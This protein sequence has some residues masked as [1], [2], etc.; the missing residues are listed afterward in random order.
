MAW[1]R[2]IGT[3]VRAE[4][5]RQNWCVPRPADLVAQ[6][7]YETSPPFL[8]IELYCHTADLQIIIA[9]NHDDNV[10]DRTLF[11]ANCGKLCRPDEYEGDPIWYEYATWLTTKRAKGGQ[12]RAGV[13]DEMVLLASMTCKR[14]D[15]LHDKIADLA[16]RIGLDAIL[17]GYSIIDRSQFETDPN[18]AWWTLL[19]VVGENLYHATD[20]S[21]CAVQIEV[22][23]AMPSPNR[24]CNLI[25]LR[26]NN[27]ISRYSR[28]KSGIHVDHMIV[29]NERCNVPIFSNQGVDSPMNKIRLK[30]NFVVL[31]IGNGFKDQIQRLRSHF[32]AGKGETINFQNLMGKGPV[33]TSMALQ[34]IFVAEFRFFQTFTRPEERL[35]ALLALTI[36]FS[37]ISPRWTDCGPTKEVA[38][39]NVTQLGDFWRTSMLSLPDQLLGINQQ[40]RAVI[41]AALGLREKAF[42][43]AGLSFNWNPD[44]EV[45]VAES[46]TFLHHPA[47]DSSS[48]AARLSFRFEI[49]EIVDEALGTM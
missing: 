6:A 41:Y 4:H 48:G 49:N 38:S 30:D 24:L 17:T 35:V 33:E 21:R 10:V 43:G 9:N 44:M 23:L 27:Q 39:N 5:A 20:S 13:V 45:A 7:F 14:A 18:I 19:E 36:V 29:P 42:A 32:F 34:M 28:E 11:A 2:F 16:E 1:M 22:S 8:D 25:F 40:V 46:S 37:D 3:L 12:K 15:N 26:E 47:H 31:W